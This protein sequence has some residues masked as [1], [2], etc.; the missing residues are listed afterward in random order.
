MS[1]DADRISQHESE[2]LEAESLDARGHDQRLATELRRG[3]FD[4]PTSSAAQ[5]QQLGER[6]RLPVATGRRRRPAAEDGER[7]VREVLDG[8]VL[9]LI[10]RIARGHR[11]PAPLPRQ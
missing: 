7:R 4:G 9:A 6:P 11:G 10:A 8:A 1:A 2:T 3:A 5:L